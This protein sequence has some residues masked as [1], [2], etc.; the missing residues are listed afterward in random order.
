MS[1]E[2]TESHQSL[3]WYRLKFLGLIVVFLSPFLAGWMAL[4]VFE[5]KPESINYGR[6]VQPVR[7]VVWPELQALDGQTYETGFGRKWTFVLFVR[8]QCLE[9][10]RSNL[11]YLRQIRVLLGRDADRLQNVLLSASEIESDMRM[12]LKE[13]PHL[14]VIEKFSDES[15]FAQF[16]ND[17]NAAS[18]G[19]TPLLYLVDPDQNY[20]MYYPPDP[21][22]HRVLE[23]I[24]K[25]M[26]LSQIG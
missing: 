24:R 5:M 15:L 4:Y 10:C 19:L 21:D 26:K 12:F 6:L 13:Y 16:A 14:A 20:M 23:D 2:V 18:V 9:S 1:E 8:G 3:L 11:F 25:L 17:D 22:E 7:K